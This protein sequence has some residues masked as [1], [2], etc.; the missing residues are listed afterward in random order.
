MANKEGNINAYKL[1]GISTCVLSPLLS[2]LPLILLRSTR[3]STIYKSVST[4]AGIVAVAS[5]V[6]ILR[7]LCVVR[8]CCCCTPQVQF[9]IMKFSL[10][11]HAAEQA[12]TEA[13][14][15]AATVALAISLLKH[16]AASSLHW[17]S[18]FATY[19]C[20]YMPFTILLRSA[21]LPLPFSRAHLSALPAA[22]AA[23]RC[24]SLKII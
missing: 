24:F 8:C 18:F 2:L 15:D 4:V 12:A 3:C 14:A 13:P 21:G 19:V 20:M 10:N 17:I 7:A 11:V 9:S 6:V 22:E 23:C 5:A 16:H 1:T